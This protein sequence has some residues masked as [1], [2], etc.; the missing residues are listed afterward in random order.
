MADQ[1]WRTV[2]TKR[3]RADLRAR[4]TDDTARKTSPGDSRPALN[5]QA[6]VS[7]EQRLTRR[8]GG[9]DGPGTRDP[10]EAGRNKRSVKF[11]PRLPLHPAGLAD[12]RSGDGRRRFRRSRR[13]GRC[14]RQRAVA[15][16]TGSG[17]FA[18]GA[19]REV[20]RQGRHR[21][22][23][24]E[25]SAE[26]GEDDCDET[27]HADGNLARIGGPSKPDVAVER[28]ALTALAAPTAPGSAELSRALGPL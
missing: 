2:R 12:D 1:V 22:Q 18:A 27:L 21:R 8:R 9:P 15:L 14:G 24:P 20:R 5:Q 10:V 28:V 16:S 11:L 13:D 26:Q 25:S 3:G 23:L 7:P 17:F 4:A 6:A 19:F